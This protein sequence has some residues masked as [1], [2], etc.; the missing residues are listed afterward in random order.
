ME[1]TMILTLLLVLVVLALLGLRLTW[2]VFAVVSNT[3]EMLVAHD[4]QSRINHVAG[5]QYLG[6][7]LEREVIPRLS[8]H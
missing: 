1:D 8:A 7:L 2:N 5:R 4:V 3:R 6:Q